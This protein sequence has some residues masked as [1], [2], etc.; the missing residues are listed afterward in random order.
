MTVLYVNAGNYPLFSNTVQ[1]RRQSPGFPYAFLA[2]LLHSFSFGELSYTLILAQERCDPAPAT[3]VC[4][5]DWDVRRTLQF[6]GVLQ[7]RPK[8]GAAQ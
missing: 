6:R 3:D 4:H 7:W 2:S 8:I 1:F 5:Y